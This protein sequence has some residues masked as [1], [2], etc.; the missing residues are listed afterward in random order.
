[1]VRATVLVF[2]LTVIC[3]Q[4]AEKS[5][6]QSDLPG[7][8]VVHLN[9]VIDSLS[10]A[11]D[12]SFNHSV[13]NDGTQAFAEKGT[14]RMSQYPDGELAVEFTG[15]SPVV[16]RPAPFT[17]RPGLWLSRATR[18]RAGAVTLLLNRDTKLFYVRAD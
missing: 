6:S 5:I 7:L 9:S 17:S 2:S 4:T 8:Y 14:W 18:D 11:A 10:L 1:M 13:W 15:I 3:C 16:G 12:G